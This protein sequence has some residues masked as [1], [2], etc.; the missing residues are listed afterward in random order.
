MS[1]MKCPQCGLVNWVTAE[2]CKRCKLPFVVHAPATPAAAP[3]AADEQPPA[4]TEEVHTDSA[5]P[6]APAETAPAHAE[7]PQPYLEPQQQQPYSEP[8]QQPYIC[9]VPPAQ[10]HAGAGHAHAPRRSPYDQSGRGEAGVFDNTLDIDL[11][12]KSVV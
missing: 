11:D 8:Q 10:G 4:A 12:R 5:A 6:A 1:S 3:P 7:P 2:A 9:A